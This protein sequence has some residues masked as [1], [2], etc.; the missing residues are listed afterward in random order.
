VKADSVLFTGWSLATL[1]GWEAMYF[2]GIVEGIQK[3]TATRRLRIVFDEPDAGADTPPDRVLGVVALVGGR[4]RERAESLAQQ[5]LR[6]VTINFA[7][8]GLPSVRPDDYLGGRLAVSHLL[9][10]GHRR[11]VH[12]NSGERETHWLEVKRAF[13]ETAAEAGLARTRA[14]VLESPLRCG[15]IQAG[16]ELMRQL[17]GRPFVPTGIVTG[18]DLMAMGA[19]LRLRERGCAVPG[20]VSVVGFDDIEAADVCSP[21]L[22]TIAADRVELGRMA[23]RQLLDS[24]GAEERLAGVHLRMRESSGPAPRGRRR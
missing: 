17:E 22:T 9:Q 19:L 23:V 10:H 3:E 2:R 11:L 7:V 5:N 15:S 13:A 8:P 4:T 20:A 18:N 12:F 21:P 14:V 6:V 1:S 16:Y 24:S